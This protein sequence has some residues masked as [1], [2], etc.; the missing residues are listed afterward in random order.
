MGDKG[1]MRE[2]ANYFLLGS[3][4]MQVNVHQDAL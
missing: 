3:I 2:F 1:L 4:L